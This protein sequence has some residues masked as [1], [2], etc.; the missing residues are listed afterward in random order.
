MIKS[1][2]G[3]WNFIHGYTTKARKCPHCG[4]TLGPPGS[5]HTC[6]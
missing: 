4:Q 1:L 6:S 5:S 2:I 3:L